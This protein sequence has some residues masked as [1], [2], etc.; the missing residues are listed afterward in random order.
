MKLGQKIDCNK[1]KYQ[2]TGSQTD[3]LSIILW[4]TQNLSILYFSDKILK[5]ELGY[6][7]GCAWLS[8]VA[9]KKD[10]PNPNSNPNSNPNC[11]AEKVCAHNESH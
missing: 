6:V 3:N 5:W 11:K 9:L 8:V 10:T 4:L 1:K 2:F 7:C